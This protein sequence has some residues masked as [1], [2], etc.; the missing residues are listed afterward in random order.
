[1]KHPSHRYIKYLLLT[2][3]NVDEM[4]LKWDLP[5]IKDSSIFKLSPPEPFDLETEE[6]I[7]WLKKEKLYGLFK[8]NRAIEE[9]YLILEDISTRE[10]IEKLL[11][12]KMAESDIA[13]KINSR[14]DRGITREGVQAFRHYFWDVSVM[15]LKDWLDI[16]KDQSERNRIKTMLRQGPAYALQITGFIDKIEAKDALKKILTICNRCVDEMAEDQPTPDMIKSLAF[17]AQTIDRIDNKLTSGGETNKEIIGRFE[18]LS[19][20]HVPNQVLPI[21]ITAP[22]GNFTGGKDPALLM[23]S[24]IIEYKKKDEN[25]LVL[26]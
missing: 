21:N 23:Q 1:M 5:K 2:N 22:L 4:L 19:I 8:K 11:I 18:R 24:T 17:L 9:A 15:R 10:T 7:K 14:W 3:Q 16:Y 13:I 12:S 20:E 6:T 26:D 25:D